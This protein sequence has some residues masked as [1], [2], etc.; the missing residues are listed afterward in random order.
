MLLYVISFFL[1][2]MKLLVSKSPIDNI[3]FIGHFSVVI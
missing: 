1:T 3:K 2:L